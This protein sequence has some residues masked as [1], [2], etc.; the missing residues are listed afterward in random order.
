[1]IVSLPIKM[2]DLRGDVWIPFDTPLFRLSRIKGGMQIFNENGMAV[3]QILKYKG[4]NTVTVGDGGGIV[5][6]E[7]NGIVKMVPVQSRDE[8]VNETKKRGFDELIFFGNYKTSH[9]EIFIKK[10]GA[11]KP[12]SLVT[13]VAHPLNE[14]LVNVKVADGENFLLAVSLCLALPV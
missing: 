2:E 14:K 13:A 4:Y 1:M 3:A 9:Y 11:L 8:E 12:T 7:R 10:P 5:V 6:M